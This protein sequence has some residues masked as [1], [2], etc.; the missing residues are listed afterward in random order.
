MILLGDSFPQ[1]EVMLASSFDPNFPFG[2]EA[3]NLEYSILSAILGNPSPPDSSAT[4]PPDLQ[5][6]RWPT[7]SIELTSD[8]TP[9]YTENQMTIQQHSDSSLTN[10]NGNAA[11][12]L[13]YPFPSDQQPAGPELAYQTPY[14][15][16]TPSI[17]QLQ[18]PFPVEQRPRTPVDSIE[19]PSKDAHSRMLL[20]SR[21]VKLTHSVAGLLS[22]MPLSKWQGINDRVT[23]P[24]D[25]TEG[26]HFLMKHLPTQYAFHTHKLIH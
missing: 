9:T 7:D 25:Y 6:S 16:Q 23:V 26:Y 5:Y 15:S 14:S 12:Y 13:T 21:F 19:L 24:Y 10:T 2:S 3:A 18:G 20:S 11:H 22:D 17:Q 8:L 4:P 1:S